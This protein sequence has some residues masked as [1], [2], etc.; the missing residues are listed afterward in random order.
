MRYHVVLW[1]WMQPNF[2]HT[3]TAEHMNVA[4]DMVHRWKGDLDVRI[5]GVTDDAAGVTQCE[6]FPL[7]TD[8]N[9][10]ANRSGPNLPSCYRRLKLFDMGTQAAMGITPGDRVVSLD[11]DS[12]VSG[13]LKPLWTKEQHFVGWAVR[14]QHHI[15][16]FNGSMFMFT[17]SENQH[18]WH[19]FDPVKTPDRVHKAGFLGSDQSWLS[20]NFARDPTA[21]NWHYPQAVSYPKE[22]ARRPLLSKGTSLVFFHGKRKPWHAE[23]QKE[24]PWISLHWRKGGTAQPSSAVQ[25]TAG[26]AQAVIA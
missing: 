9:M 2:K 22:A 26:A 15:R 17:A 3:Y 10:L 24:S 13:P 19:N 23:V 7:W 21:G 20:Y 6:T 14:G 11:L 1:K 16:V 18:V 4:A 8:F 25:V 12:L 5:I